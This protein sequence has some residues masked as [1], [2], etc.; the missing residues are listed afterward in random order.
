MKYRV[1]ELRL[2]YIR[3]ILAGLRFRAR[4]QEL[5]YINETYLKGVIGKI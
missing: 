1:E 4:Q 3:Q 2:V 5:V